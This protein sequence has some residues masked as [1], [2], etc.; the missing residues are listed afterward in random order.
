MNRKVSYDDESAK[1]CDL[2]VTTPNVENNTKCSLT[3]IPHKESLGE[4][5]DKKYRKFLITSVVCKLNQD[6]TTTERYDNINEMICSGREMHDSNRTI[7]AI[8]PNSRNNVES[9]SVS[10]TA[11]NKS[12]KLQTGLKNRRSIV[13]TKKKT[14]PKVFK[15]IHF[16]VTP[17]H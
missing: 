3:L 4:S 1:Y 6:V 17:R 15:N 8:T 9:F 12:F 14:H 16:D 10:T 5:K 13:R 2:M 11:E 7:L